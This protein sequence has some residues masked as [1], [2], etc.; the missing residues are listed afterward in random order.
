[1]ARRSRG[2]G[3]G[4]TV[5][6]VALVVVLLAA[7]GAE[8]AYLWVRDEPGV[9]AARPVTTGRLA[10]QS[11]VDV[12]SRTVE[13]VLSTTWRD[14]DAHADRAADAMTE[15]FAGEY[16]ESVAGLRDRFV[17]DRTEQEMKVVSAGVVRAT[18]HEVQVLLFLDQYVRKAG[19]DAVVR[20]RRALVTMVRGDHGWLV[21]DLRTR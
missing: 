6:L 11:V 8:A 17:A 1:M 16:R 7:V 15:E 13:D 19:A 5:L 14:Y 20:P 4:T 2:T 3:R 10:Q 18:S 12:A 21:S 9:S